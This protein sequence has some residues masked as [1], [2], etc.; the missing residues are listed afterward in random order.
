MANDIPACRDV[1]KDCGQGH[2]AGLLL[3]RYLAELNKPESKQEILKASKDALSN[4]NLCCLYKKAFN[5]RSQQYSSTK[6]TTQTLDGCRLIIG[7]GNASP[8]E[9]GL[10]LHHTYG[11]PIIPGSALKGM[12]AHHA[13]EIFFNP[14]AENAKKPRAR[15]E[16]FTYEQ[17][18]FLFGDS[19]QAGCLTFHDAWIYPESLE[20]ALCRDII[21]PHHQEYY[22]NQGTHPPT[23]FDSPVPVPFLSVCGKFQV[24]L[25][26]DGISPQE[27]HKWIALTK[28][29]LRDALANRGIGGKTSS[30]Y[31]RMEL[32]SSQ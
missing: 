15:T 24:L 1:L 5:Q 14:D 2:H 32:N 13:W 7:L 9:V 19:S 3:A 29:L 10:T 22:S 26:C 28:H 8:L 6:Y 27:C 12:C 20:K 30:G 17:Y 23:D 21:T 31:G 18:C 16:Y 4:E 25:S 11:T